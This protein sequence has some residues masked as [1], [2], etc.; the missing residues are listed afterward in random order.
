MDKFVPKQKMSKKARKQAAKEKRVVWAF[1]PV[2][3]KIESK[4]LYKR[5]SAP[6][7]NDDTGELFS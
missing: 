6:R 2:T 7:V 1:P 5:K 3:K 4:K